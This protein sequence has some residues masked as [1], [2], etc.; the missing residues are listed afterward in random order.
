MWNLLPPI[1]FRAQ[2]QADEHHA[3][4][5]H[6]RAH[7]LR[8]VFSGNTGRRVLSRQHFPLP[9]G[10]HPHRCCLFVS[11]LGHSSDYSSDIVHSLKAN[12]NKILG[13]LNALFSGSITSRSKMPFSRPKLEKSSHCGLFRWQ[14]SP[15]AACEK[16][17]VH[18]ICFRS[19]I[20]SKTQNMREKGLPI[21][22]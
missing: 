17:G 7:L 8:T 16:T 10:V 19:S 1:N 5:H 2:E 4:F 11:G 22:V 15:T 18:S 14:D 6:N 13:P 9:S 3:V 21:V 20:S 12:C